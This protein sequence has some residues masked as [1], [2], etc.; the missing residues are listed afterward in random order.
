MI[1]SWSIFFTFFCFLLMNALNASL[2][3]VSMVNKFPICATLYASCCLDHNPYRGFSNRW[4]SKECH[5]PGSG[6]LIPGPK[7]KC[8]IKNKIIILKSNYKNHSLFWFK[9]FSE[10]LSMVSGAFTGSPTICHVCE[11]LYVVNHSKNI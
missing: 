2:W 7:V 1:I 10:Y 11:N 5:W 6:L 9:K 8:T 4:R 3:I